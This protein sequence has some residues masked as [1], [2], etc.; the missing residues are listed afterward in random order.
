MTN[1]LKNGVLKIK[2]WAWISE[3]IF[4]HIPQTERNNPE[5]VT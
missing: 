2:L 1:L 5:R 4:H 3:S